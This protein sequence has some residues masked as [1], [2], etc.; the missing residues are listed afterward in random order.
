MTQTDGPSYELGILSAE[1]RRAIE[2]DGIVILPPNAAVIRELPALRAA[3][4]RL[5]E[6]EGARAGWEGKEQHF[7]PGK[8]FED[9]ANR[10]GNLVNKIPFAA[11]L[12]A[13]PELLEAAYRVLRSEMKVGS[14]LMREPHKGHGHQSL[15]IDW[16]PRDH[17]DEPFGGVVCM[18]LLDDASVANGAMRYIPGTHVRL[19]WPDDQIDVAAPHPDERRAEAPAGSIIVMNLNLWHAG[20]LNATGDRRRSIFVNI[21]RRDLPQLLNQKRYLSAETVNRLT[22]LQQY[23]LAVRAEDA[24]QPQKSVGPGDRYRELHGTPPPQRS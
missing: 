19:G 9:G 18:L 24:E 4:D 13:L 5:L 21:R 8:P 17:S 11:D 23:L 14:V 1:Q 22:P 2:E 20:A 16:L 6:E 3:V 7:A 12:I 10:L 15:H